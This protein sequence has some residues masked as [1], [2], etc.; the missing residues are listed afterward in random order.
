MRG[1]SDGFKKKVLRY[2]GRKSATAAAKKFGVSTVSIWKWKKHYMTLA[3]KLA[4]IEYRKKAKLSNKPVLGIANPIGA[5]EGLSLQISNEQI[6][7]ELKSWI[8]GFKGKIN[9]LEAFIEM[10]END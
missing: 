7:G 2:E 6:I 3:Q 1:Y 10:L 5:E 4:E 8:D 9:M